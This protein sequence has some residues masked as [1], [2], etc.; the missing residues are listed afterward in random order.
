MN[1]PKVADLVPEGVK[2]DVALVQRI[3][4]EHI[5]PIPKYQH[6]FVIVQVVKICSGRAGYFGSITEVNR[7]YGT[8]T[9]RIA[10]AIVDGVMLE[11]TLTSRVSR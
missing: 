7:R 6:E 4:D 9:G 3:V 10:K 1:S 5:K 8:V 2:V 11:Q